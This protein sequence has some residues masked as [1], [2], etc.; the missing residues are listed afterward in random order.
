MLLFRWVVM[1][2]LLAAAVSFAFYAGTGQPHYKR[3]GLV[4]LKWTVI[5]A[6]FFF[7][8]VLIGRI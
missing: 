7:A 6:V 8:V 1:A 3:W 4:V 2:L 5:A